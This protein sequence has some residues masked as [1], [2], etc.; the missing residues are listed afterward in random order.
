M[1]QLTVKQNKF[2]RIVLFGELSRDLVH[3]ALLKGQLEQVAQDI[4][5]SSF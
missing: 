4:V 1:L 3:P 2:H 5:Q